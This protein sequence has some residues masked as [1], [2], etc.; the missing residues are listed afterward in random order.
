MNIAIRETDSR[1]QELFDS[2]KKVYSF[3]KLSSI[4]NCPYAAYL[5]YIIKQRNKRQSVWGVLGGKFH[6]K[7]EEITN[8]ECD[9]E[10]LKG[11][12][13]QEFEYLDL[14][15]LEFPK[16]Y[17]GEDSIRKNWA[18]NMQHFADTFVPLKGNFSTE[19]LLIL[20]LDEE[21]YIQGYAD[22]IRHNEDGTIT[23]LDW[24]T[25]SLYSNEEFEHAAHQ[26]KIYGLAKEADGETVKHLAWIFMKYVE[27]TYTGKLR[28]N[29]KKESEIKKVIERR[30]LGT[31]LIRPIKDKLFAAGY[32]EMS[33]DT[34][35]A[36]VTK[37]NSI[38]CLPND[39]RN[40]FVIKPYIKT[41]PFD[42]SEKDKT[43]KYINDTINEFE[44]RGSNS[45]D[46]E[47]RE[48]KKVNKSGKESEDIFYCTSL[49]DFGHTCKYI[50]SY[51]NEKLD[52][53]HSQ[54]DD[55]GLF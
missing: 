40:Q 39:I 7:L 55:L 36:T 2:G 47:P 34:Y 12:V 43:L 23:I 30:R 44:S 38:D 4:G 48:F 27:V 22:L 37:T 31:E 45:R 54:S 28:S 53:P 49:C 18:K 24:K 15:G 8:G 5:Q 14:L 16:D 25:S 20:K 17:K 1:L 13:A 52:Q 33:I 35:I 11:I 10:E 3:S 26:L 9:V 46:W 42:D 21:H 6:D 19:E 32:D 41:T 51:L 50:Q 29:A